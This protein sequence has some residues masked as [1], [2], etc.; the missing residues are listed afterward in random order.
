MFVRVNCRIAH[1]LVTLYIIT[2]FHLCISAPLQV[3]LFLTCTSRILWILCQTHKSSIIKLS[4]M[5][6]EPFSCSFPMFLP[7]FLCIL[8]ISCFIICVY[9]FVASS[10]PEAK[11]T[12]TIA[13]APLHKSSQIAPPDY[14]D[15]STYDL[16]QLYFSSKTFQHLV[17]FNFRFATRL[18]NNLHYFTLQRITSLSFLRIEFHISHYNLLKNFESNIFCSIF[19]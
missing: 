7:L 8:S 6:N 14:F 17:N 16:Q 19:Y 10:C 4:E 13:W 3:P 9:L 5:P 18:K 2:A 11:F 15:S 12:A 1:C